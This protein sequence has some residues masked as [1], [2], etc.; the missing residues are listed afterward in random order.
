MSGNAGLLVSS[1]CMEQTHVRNHDLSSAAADRFHALRQSAERTGPVERSDSMDL[2]SVE[3]AHE[4]RSS[5]N[6]ILLA[7]EGALRFPGQTNTVIRALPT[8][9][10]S[11]VEGARESKASDAP[12]GAGHRQANVIQADGVR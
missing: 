5:L 12:L 11:D 7:A 4:I 8:P 9:R 3:N 2:G 1:E 6:E 10:P